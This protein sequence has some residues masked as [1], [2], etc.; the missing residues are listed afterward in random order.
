MLR[1]KVPRIP[2]F[3]FHLLKALVELAY[4]VKHYLLGV[5]L[6]FPIPLKDPD[7]PRRD[8]PIPLAHSESKPRTRARKHNAGDLACPIL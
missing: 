1:I 5:E 2:Q 7:T 6:I 4:S 3:H 8:N